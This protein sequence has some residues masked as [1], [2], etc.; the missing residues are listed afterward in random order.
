M[1]YLICIASSRIK[2]EDA[3]VHMAKASSICAQDLMTKNQLIIP[4]TKDGNNFYYLFSI[5]DYEGIPVLFVARDDSNCLYLCDCVEFRDFQRWVISKISTN[6]LEL[7]INQKITIF[8][9]LKEDNDLKIIATYDYNSGEVT[10]EKIAF[11]DISQE[12]LPEQDAYAYIMH[13]NIY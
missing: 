12:D 13:D 7:V 3:L 11:S 1:L 2:K 4:A 6:T 8:N 5:M 9:A 10:Q